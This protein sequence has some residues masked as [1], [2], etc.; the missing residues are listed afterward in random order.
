P[1]DL[2]QGPSVDDRDRRVLGDGSEPPEFLLRDG[3]PPEDRQDTKGLSA[4][5]ERLSREAPDTL[6]PRPLRTLPALGRRVVQQKW[7]AGRPDPT[8]LEHSQRKAAEVPVETR[9]IL[10]G[11]RLW[12]ARTGGQVEAA[13]LVG[14]LR[15]QPA[16]VADVPGAQQPDPCEGDTGLLGET[17]DDA[18]EH[19]LLGTLAR[20]GEGNRL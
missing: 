5:V 3:G 6:S 20:D 19:S 13:C 12:R 1:V 10:A 4:E 2:R 9:P 17:L 14:T 16:R 18:R 8:Y 11:G 15:S 7:R